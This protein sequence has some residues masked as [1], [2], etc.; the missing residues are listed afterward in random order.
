MKLIMKIINIFKKIINGFN[1]KANKKSIVINHSYIIINIHNYPKEDN[2]NS[3][4]DL[5]F[6]SLGLHNIHYAKYISL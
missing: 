1:T 5:F 3:N 6:W 4:T 2:T